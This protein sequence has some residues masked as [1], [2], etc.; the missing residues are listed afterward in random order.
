MWICFWDH[1]QQLDM[2]KINVAYII[3]S[4]FAGCHLQTIF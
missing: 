3:I 1:L 4:M 2:F